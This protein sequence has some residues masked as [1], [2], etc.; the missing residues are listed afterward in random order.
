MGGRHKTPSLAQ[1][2]ERWTVMVISYPA[3]PGSIPGVRKNTA[4][5]VEWSNTLDSSSSFFGS[6]RSNRISRISRSSRSESRLS[7]CV[8]VG[9][10]SGI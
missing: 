10:R 1:L 5:V 9:L 2:A 4:R 3:A 6:M 8:R 7:G